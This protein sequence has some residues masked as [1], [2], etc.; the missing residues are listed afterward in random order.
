[1]ANPYVKVGPFNENT[2]PPLSAANM[3]LFDQG[4]FDAHFQPA[5]EVWNNANQSIANNAE[6]TLGFNAEQFDTDVI[7][8]TATNNDRLTCKTAGKYL[9]Y[10]TLEFAANATGQRYA[11]IRKNGTSAMAY[12]INVSAGAT[13]PTTLGHSRVLD[14][15]VNDYVTIVVYQ[16]S[17]AALNVSSAGNYSP[18]FGMVR[19]A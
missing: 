5:A 6:T 10:F 1:M 12:D 11:Y 8:D 3:N 18:I 4:I 17:G 16:N 9:V 2:T 15:A 19:V 7:H 13:L 14:L